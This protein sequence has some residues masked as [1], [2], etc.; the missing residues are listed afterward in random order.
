MW[1]GGNQGGGGQMNML[2]S[3]LGGGGVQ[4]QNPGGGGASMLQA[5]LNQ[6]M[7]RGPIPHQIRMGGG[8]MMGQVSARVETPRRLSFFTVS[9][10]VVR[11]T[12]VKRVESVC[13]SSLQL[14]IFTISYQ[15]WIAFDRS[16]RL[17]QVKSA[18]QFEPWTWRWKKLR[19]ILVSRRIFWFSYWLY[20][21]Y[22]IVN[23]QSS[24]F[25]SYFVSASDSQTQI[26]SGC[27]FVPFECVSI[28]KLP[29]TKV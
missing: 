25:R 1:G 22:F 7:H 10:N 16:T 2:Q 9:L 14:T 28:E 21:N 27:I 18:I 24:S 13:E 4:Q 20:V 19:V 11:F 15:F 6:P 12:S 3:Q 5:Q 23:A 29:T 17:G 8:Q 26:R